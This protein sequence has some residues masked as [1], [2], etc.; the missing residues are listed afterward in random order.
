MKRLPY[1]FTSL[2]GRKFLAAVT[3]FI[4]LSFLLLHAF[5]NL[6][7]FAADTVDGVPAINAYADYLRSMATPLMPKSVLLWL[8]RII[9]IVA[10]VLHVFV[11]LSLAKT[12]RAARPIAYHQ[13]PQ[14]TA[15]YAARWVLAS[16]L[17][18]LLFII[19][20][21]SHFSF[22]VLTPFAFIEGD[23]YHNLAS[24]FQ[25]PFYVMFY[26]LALAAL[27]FHLHHGIWSLTQTLGL[28]NPDR[29]LMFRLLASLIT[30]LLVSLFAS[31]PLAFYFGLLAFHP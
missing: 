3:G 14:K 9:L 15:S 6:N 30:A 29:N 20:H 2:I 10:F 31:I 1:L 23:I 13:T 16:G 7:S 22:G 17:I 28:D 18:V 27:G 21:L 12:N 25:S 8:I 5:G 24:A 19:F 26:L 4:L 11:V